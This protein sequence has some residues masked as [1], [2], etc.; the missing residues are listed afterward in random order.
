MGKTDEYQF[1]YLDD[2][3]RFADQINGALFQG[4]QIVK[5]EELL[6]ADTQAV[7]LGKE[8]GRREHAKTVV[9]KARMWKGKRL[10]ILAVE[11]QSYVDHQMVI[12]NM[13]SESLGYHKQ[14]KQKKREHGKAGDLKSGKDEYL[15]GIEKK[16]KFTPIIT[17]VVYYGMDHPWDGAKCLHE[18]ID[19]DEEL[20][21]YVTNYKLNLY[22]CHEHDTFDEYQTGLRQIFETLRYAKD[23]EKLGRILAENH[24]AYSGIDADTRELL[25]VVANVKIPETCK[26]MKDGEERYDMC[27]AFEDMRLEGVEEGIERG[28]EK[29]IEKGIYALIQTCTELGIPEDVI[30]SK[31][32]EKFE[33]SN[34]RVM[35][36]LGKH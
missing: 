14:W 6:P 20:K 4:R 9:D 34:E 2:D 10:H 36:Y 23:K 1:D 25:S 30:V 8:A 33:L 5:S 13:L 31:C 18:L 27:K 19:I 22:D 32:M 7:Y 29:G 17:L 3:R 24:A 15:S 35:G 12:R 26:V 21:A 16:E 11:N 28:I